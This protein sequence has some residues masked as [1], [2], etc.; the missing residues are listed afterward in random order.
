[1]SKA[2]VSAGCSQQ[3]WSLLCQHL[4]ASGSSPPSGSRHTALSLAAPVALSPPDSAKVSS[5]CWASVHC[6]IAALCSITCQRCTA[7][8][9]FDLLTC[10]SLQQNS[11]WHLGLQQYC[12]TV[13]AKQSGRCILAT[14]VMHLT[15]AC[16]VPSSPVTQT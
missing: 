14:A 10:C 12:V 5:L 8:V 4:R 11:I 1:M 3:Q 7:Q 15:L 6:R 13:A 16:A 2:L 9:C